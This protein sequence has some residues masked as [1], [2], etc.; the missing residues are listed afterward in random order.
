LLSLENRSGA[1]AAQS[2]GTREIEESFKLFW[3]KYM[4]VFCFEKGDSDRPVCGV[5]NVPLIQDQVAIDANAPWLGSIA[6]SL[7]PVTRVVVEKKRESNAP[8]YR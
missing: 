7:C 3:E 8:S 4:P 6:C 5:H 2:V 1:V